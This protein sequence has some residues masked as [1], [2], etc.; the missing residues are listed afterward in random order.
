MTTSWQ[1]TVAG[2]GC[3]AGGVYLIAAQK[4]AI[5]GAGLIAAGLGL[6]RAKDANVV[7]TLG[8]VQEA[9][10]KE[11]QASLKAANNS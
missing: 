10:I 11:N 2:I 8:Q 1:T 4:G 9:T 7:S 6:V 5:E 3:I